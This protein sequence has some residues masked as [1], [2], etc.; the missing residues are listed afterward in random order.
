MPSLS[1]RLKA[2]GVQVGSQNLPPPQKRATFPIESI[3]E[4]QIQ[5]TTLGEAFVV[6]NHYPERQLQGREEL[7]LGA[8]LELIAAWAGEPR[9]V[10]LAP[11]S[12]IFL[13]TETSGLSGGTGTYAFLIGVGKFTRQGFHLAQYFMRDPFEEPAHLAAFNQFLGGCDGLV[14]FNGK[15][16]DVPLLNTRF[17]SNGE[18]SPL[19]GSAHID[20]L[21][22]ARRLWRDRLPSRALGY[23]E[24]HIL[25]VRRTHEDV[26]GWMIPGM[27]FEYLR[28]GDA[29]PLKSIFY[30]NAMDIL[31]LAALL[32]HIGFMLEEPLG[33]R[34]DH[35][36]DFF[37][38][39]KLFEDLG[40]VD[41]AVPLFDHALSHDIPFSIR[42]DILE[43]WSFLEKRRGN[44]SSAI[45]MWEEA[46]QHQQVYAHVELAKYYEHRARDY[47]Q[48]IKWTERAMKTISQT[49]FSK[50]DRREWQ[51]LLDH[52]Y[53][54]LLR[55]INAS[56]GDR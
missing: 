34:V 18:I 1:D 43:R 10:E 35:P 50:M 5:D 54:R 13:D 4:G 22:L 56:G 30:H 14:T 19:K 55:K 49:D 17:I 11:E 29:R 33:G 38:I 24:E 28:S 27:Y 48:A 32:N 31:S 45:Q 7:H 40:L 36:Q 3:I 2:L 8:R 26:P 12:F 15:A 6:E 42:L 39:G 53:G 25:Q 16:F 46:A 23:L 47:P 51:P 52:R 37:A 20:L 21:P 41:A 9:L 44:F